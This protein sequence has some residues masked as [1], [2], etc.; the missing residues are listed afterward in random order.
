[1]T[2]DGWHVKLTERMPVWDELVRDGSW[3]LKA[4]VPKGAT[5][6]I[7]HAALYT[8]ADPEVN[9]V[10]R[11]PKKSEMT[12]GDP[13]VHGVKFRWRPL[14]VADTLFTA[15]EAAGYDAV[16]VVQKGKLVGLLRP[17]G[18]E[19]DIR[20]HGDKVLLETACAAVKDD[21]TRLIVLHFKM[22]DDAGHRHGWLSEE[23]YAE[24]E[25]ISGHLRTIRACIAE[26]EKAGGV[27]TALVVTSDHGGTPNKGHGRDDDDNRLV[28]LAI[29][30]PGVKAGHE[31]ASPVR[32]VDVS[33]TVLRLL[34]LP[35]EAIPTLSGAEISEIL[36][37]Q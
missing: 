12:G 27:P 21:R 11:E 20:A 16:A 14:K 30:G 24:A 22:T 36:G 9:G 37:S 18:D 26:A 29:V 7:S 1:V 10:T 6:V 28:P 34:G 15:T 19:T 8:G 13:R 33:A 2:I 5:T 25:K 31:I 35:A 32:L 23:Q 17:D 4:E 3:T